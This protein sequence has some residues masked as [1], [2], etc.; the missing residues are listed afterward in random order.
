[1]QIPN[2]SSKPD[3]LRIELPKKTDFSHM[4]NILRS[5]KLVTVCE[6]SQ[7]PNMAE[8][9]AGAGTATFMVMGDTCTRGCAYCAIKTARN[10]NPIDPDEPTKIA[11]AIAEMKLD[12]AV[13][14]S[15][16]RDDLPDGGSNHFANV[17]REVKKKHPKTYVEVLIP[18]FAGDVA[19]LKNIV[20][21]KPDVIAHNIETIK[22]LQHPVRDRR[23]NYAQSLTVLENVKAMNPDIF[24]KSAIMVGLGE[25]E[26]EVKEAM[27][28]LRN[29]TCD[30]LTIGQY[31]KPKN[32]SLKI[33]EYVHPKVFK[34]YEEY[35]S[36]IGFM[37]TA[38]GPFVRSSYRA[39]E[40][41][42]KGK[43]D[44]QKQ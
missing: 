8:C 30:V 44:Q 11:E 12:Y 25:T 26:E 31:M 33:Q 27:Q 37:Y 2:Y 23:A 34:S 39:G 21:A 15:V 16:D 29:S 5:K 4:K 3:W 38:A 13:I 24:T 6:E 1:M 18:D 36:K 14:T 40:F 17:I 43:L 22:R 41:F 7:C 10:G 28:D 32:R 20:D 9:W 35:G 19:A 42:I